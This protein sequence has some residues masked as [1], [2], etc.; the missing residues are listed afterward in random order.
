M[1]WQNRLTQLL[2]IQY[3]FIQA[4]MLGV[5]S[6]EM[7]ASI[8]NLGGLGS[9][10]VGGLSPEKTL[11]LIK[12]TKLL[13]D[14]PFA[15]NLFAHDIPAI[16]ISI[17][18]EMAQFLKRLGSDHHLDFSNS[19]IDALKFHSYTEQIQILLDEQIPIVSFTFGVLTDEI[20]ATFKARGVVLIGTA[21]CVKEAEFLEKK[22]MDAITAQGI[23]A[24]G[25][26]GTFL[27]SSDQSIPQIGSMSL[28][29]QIADHVSIP[30]L[31]SGGIYDG[32]TIKASLILGAE[33]V[34]IGS[35]FITSQESLAI[36]AY[37]ASLQNALD[38]DSVL[39]RSFSGRWARGLKNQFMAEMDAEV[40]RS[41]MIIPDYPIQNSLT[42]VLRSEAQKKNNAQ[43]TN[44][45][46]GQSASQ[47]QVK[48]SGAI[49]N[50]LIQQTE[51][52]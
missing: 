52:L 45:W 6:P 37:K 16:N 25:H 51:R 46:A 21:T 13:T 34:Q 14:R 26:R 1:I 4:P 29:P 48:S 8:S 2:G 43:F 38:T 35:A 3:P 23:E 36:A 15:V 44:L 49:F 40:G 17:A 12:K 47:V 27:T 18:E 41:G 30:V 5:T 50:D 31:A 28:I 24:G 39:T 22:G 11:E 42:A 33:G 9:L 32:R 10:P 19:Q 7:V 20:I